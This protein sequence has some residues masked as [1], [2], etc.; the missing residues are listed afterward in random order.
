[1]VVPFHRS[2]EFDTGA[3]RG[4]RIGAPQCSLPALKGD[5]HDPTPHGDF[6]VAR[7]RAAVRLAHFHDDLPELRFLFSGPPI[8]R[9]VHTWGNCLG[10][11]LCQHRWLNLEEKRP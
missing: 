3:C 9:V 11:S 5:K 7:V 1:V 10:H 8:P 6:G 2:R 4:D